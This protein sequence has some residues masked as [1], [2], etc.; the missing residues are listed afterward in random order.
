[1]TKALNDRANWKDMDYITQK[2]VCVETLN[3]F[4]LKCIERASLLTVCISSKACVMN[5]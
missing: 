1:M 2:C 5:S 3:N 4:P